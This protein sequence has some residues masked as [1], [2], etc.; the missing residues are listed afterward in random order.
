VSQDTPEAGAGRL[1]ARYERFLSPG[2]IE[3]IHR[4]AE[5][6]AGHSVQH[7]N[8]TKEGGG[9]AEILEHLVP[10][11]ND[12][13]LTA[14][15]DV[16]KGTP[17]FFEATKKIHN[18]LHGAGIEW[19]RED[20]TA[21]LEM[22][23][24]NRGVVDESADTVILHDPQPLPLAE[25][26]DR[27]S[28]KRVWRCHIS[29]SDADERVWSFLRQMAER[30]DASIY[31]L[32]EYARGLSMDEFIIPP[33]IDPLSDKNREL[34]DDEVRETVSKLGVDPELPIVLQ[35][36][37]FDY[38]KDPVGVL[39][40]FRIVRRWT[41]CQL[42]LAGGGASDDPEGERVLAEVRAAAEDVPSVHILSLPPDSHVQIN[43]L[44][45]AA[46]VIVQK[47]LRE[48][49]GLVVTE[50]MWKGKPVVGG[51]VGGIRHQ[52]LHGSSGYLVSTPEGLAFRLR[53]LLLDPEQAK[54]MGEAAREFVRANFLLPH[55]LRQWMLVLLAVQKPR[56]PDVDLG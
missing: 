45:R 22:A 12:V 39:A 4:I 24:I 27:R 7:V 51:A 15:W 41:D 44:Q 48:G 17:R 46:S 52:I 54:R 23:E 21:Y 19:T 37:R 43:A 47:S 1:L 32:P 5:H 10:L 42:V 29:L 49:F 28:G 30:C 36:S 14:K 16:V 40:A 33:A 8:S 2:Q 25:A 53:Q 13:G 6:L 35:V 50:A 34:T 56:T 18:A 31:H 38:L 55:Y 11:M 26:A 3:D 9:V 20:E